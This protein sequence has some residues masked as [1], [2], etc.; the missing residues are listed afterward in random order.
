M[1]KRKPHRRAAGARPMEMPYL[2]VRDKVM[3]STSSRVQVVHV[4]PFPIDANQ[5]LLVVT[6][7]L[8]V[9]VQFTFTGAGFSFYIFHGDLLK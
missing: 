1:L 6:Y 3:C 4:H 7:F 5:A 9:L 8:S 2:R